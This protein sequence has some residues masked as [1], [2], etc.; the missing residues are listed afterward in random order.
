MP[1][2]LT[3][4]QLGISVHR[5]FITETE[6]TSLLQEID[7]S[8]IRKKYQTSHWDHVITGYPSNHPYFVIC[9][10]VYVS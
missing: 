2:I 9:L 3:H 5:E 8:L 7:P 4:E 1:S 6:Q 10:F